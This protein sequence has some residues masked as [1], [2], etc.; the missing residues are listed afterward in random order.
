MFSSL[1]PFSGFYGSIHD[2]YMDGVLEMREAEVSDCDWENV[3]EEYAKEYVKKL[4]EWMDVSLEY[5]ELV[6]PKEYNF[7]SDRIFAKIS[8][9]DF[10]KILCAVKGA[11]LNNKVR[12]MFT[13]RSGFISHYPNNISEWGRISTW[14]HNQIGAVLAAYVDKYRESDNIEA[15]IAESI[16]ENGTLE[17]IM[18]ES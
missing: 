3:F 16:Y 4:A 14:D 8:R 18:L 12:Q 9:S 7:M 6:S 15:N 17:S 10:A 2:S 13:S 11:T 5:E 1:I